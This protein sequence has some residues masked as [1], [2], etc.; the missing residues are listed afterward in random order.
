MIEWKIS[1]RLVP[2]ET[3]V[4]QMHKRVDAI[5]T[6]NKNQLVWMLEHPSIYTGGTS[7]KDEHILKSN[8]IPIERS[9]RGGS[10]TYHGPGQRVIYVMLDLRKQE[11]DIKQFVWNLEQWIILSLRELGVKGERRKNRVGIWIEKEPLLNLR[12]QLESI[13]DFKIA[14][15]GLRLK[16]WI[17]FYGLSI[18]VNPNLKHFEG[19]IPCG[20]DGFGV[21]SLHDLGLNTSLAELDK[22]LK[23]KFYSVFKVI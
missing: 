6:E 22:I 20:N 14:S 8:K 21:T 10:Y 19:I 9:G 5:N 18:N 7:S 11:K 16:R 15:I 17:S 13:Q 2:F 1:K 3:A 12:E 23:D 4:D